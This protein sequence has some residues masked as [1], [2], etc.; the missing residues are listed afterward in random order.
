MKQQKKMVKEDI[1]FLECPNWV[2]NRRSHVD[3][4]IIDKPNGRYEIKGLH[5]LPSHFDKIVLYSLIHKIYRES[6][7]S[8]NMAIN[9]IPEQ[10]MRILVK[11]MS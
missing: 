3:S 9:K 6:A 1:N 8:N 10:I 7:L 11:K 5:G 2:L 4:F